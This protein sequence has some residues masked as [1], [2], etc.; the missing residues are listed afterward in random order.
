M[1]AAKDSFY[2]TLRDRLA[3]LNPARTVTVNG[4]VRP[5][6]MVVE[7]EAVSELPRQPEVFYLEWMEPDAAVWTAASAPLM[8][9]K[10]VIG[11]E[12]QGTDATGGQDR[13][14]AMTAMDDE[15]RSILSPG[16]C[17]VHDYTQTPAVDLQQTVFWGAG[18][19]KPVAGKGARL[20]RAA[21]VDVYW[22]DEEIQQ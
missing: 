7:N 2:I 8:R 9:L 14:R 17:A 13:G 6:M 10:A 5:G 18:K 11:Y 4:D 3:A 22:P 12:N 15:L 1:Q 19:W 21:E 20:Q 16:R